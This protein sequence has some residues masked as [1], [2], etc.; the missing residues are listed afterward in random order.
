MSRALRRHHRQ[1]MVN[2]ARALFARWGDDEERIRHTAP[3][4]AD[5]LA[6]C[7]CYSCGNPRRH[8]GFSVYSYRDEMRT[9]QEILSDIDFRDQLREVEWR[10]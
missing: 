1:R 4:L 8:L 5:N 6:W 7:S 10:P 2:R 3:R 9:R